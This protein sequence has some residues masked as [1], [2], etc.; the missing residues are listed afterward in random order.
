M[1]SIQLARKTSFRADHVV[2]ERLVAEIVERLQSR[3]PGAP[4]DR[5]VLEGVVRDGFREFA[6]ARIQTFVAVFVERRAR[7]FLEHRRRYVHIGQRFL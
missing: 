3:Y 2:D 1:P 4:V 6:T 7:L 5:A